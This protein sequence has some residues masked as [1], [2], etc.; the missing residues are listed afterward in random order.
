MEGVRDGCDS[1][2]GVDGVREVLE[3][4]RQ[5]FFGVTSKPS[6][7]ANV[8]LFAEPLDDVSTGLTSDFFTVDDVLPAGL[9]RLFFGVISSIELLET[10][11]DL[12]GVRSDGI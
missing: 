1:V 11:G 7:T 5:R 8:D 12:C 4:F 9:V 6:S 2:C 3:A 10:L